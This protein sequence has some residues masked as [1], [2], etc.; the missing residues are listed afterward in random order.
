MASISNV[1]LRDTLEKFC[2]KLMMS[3][4]DKEK[5]VAMVM[6]ALDQAYP[7]GIPQ[8]VLTDPSQK[9]NLLTALLMAPL[10]QKIPELRFD[11]TLFF[12][13][14]LNA[15][16]TKTLF[17]TFLMDL[18]K[19]EPDPKKRRTEKEID[20]EVNDLLENI[21][22]EQKENQESQTLMKSKAASYAFERIY[23]MLFGMTTQRRPV[24][25]PVNLG[26]TSGFIDN[27]SAVSLG[28]GSIH[29][30]RAFSGDTTTDAYVV[31]QGE[32]RLAGISGLG[33]EE[34]IDLQKR[35]IL[36]STPQNTRQ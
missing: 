8:D 25:V 11:L 28:G 29:E 16:E 32:Q 13:A 1:T 36:P 34:I 14:E 3:P 19:L 20:D 12:K 17:K 2:D 27:Y 23:I 31:W 7:E 18:N 21:K 24:P 5:A 4:E 35:G 30:G 6:T 22:A 9:K 33:A 26:N 10:M 15:Q